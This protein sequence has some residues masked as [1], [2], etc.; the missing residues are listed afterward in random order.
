MGVGGVRDIHADILRHGD[1]REWEGGES[2][3]RWAALRGQRGA[4]G[5][6]GPCLPPPTQ[7]HTP[8]PCAPTP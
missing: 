7:T 6:G 3:R 2:P 4:E 5:V 8:Q 1:A